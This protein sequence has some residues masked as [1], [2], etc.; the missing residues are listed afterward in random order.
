ML[1]ASL[2]ALCLRRRGHR[3]EA[4]EG[5]PASPPRPQS[6]AGSC[7]QQL[8]VVQLVHP[9]CNSQSHQP[10]A[11]HPPQ[12]QPQPGQA[13]VSGAPKPENSGGP[14]SSNCVVPLE[15]LGQCLI[16]SSQ[17]GAASRSSSDKETAPPACPLLLPAGQ[18]S[19]LCW[20]EKTWPACAQVFPLGGTRT[21]K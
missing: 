8:V 15:Q 6:P 16:E 7:N 11:P 12:P 2:P 1:A 17:A 14:L 9:L 18:Q 19:N 13:Q 21:K 3:A 4:G 20:E 5:R 10:A